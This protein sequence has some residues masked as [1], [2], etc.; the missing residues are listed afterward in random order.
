MKHLKYWLVALICVCFAGC[1]EV[2]EDIVVNADGSGTYVV[3]MDMGQLIDMMQTY[4]GEEEMAKNG[5]DR[6]IDTTIS[7]KSI[8]DSSKSLTPEQKA[9]MREGRL[10]M[11]MNVKEKIFIINTSF[12]YKTQADLQLLM[13]TQG[14][15]TGM[16]DMLKNVFGGGKGDDDQDGGQQNGVGDFSGLYN[17]TV[18]EGLLSKQINAEKYKTLME[19]PEMAQVKQMGASAMEVSYTS[20]FKF[21]RPVKK[22]DNPLIKLSPDKKTATMKYNILEILDSANKFSYNIEY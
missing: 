7:M 21:P 19:K 14:S 4:M 1:Y 11:K 8:A 15:G 16:T 10:Y 17:V 18:K 6:V 5:M 13:A 2:N 12:P 20:T 22:V 9:A 3:N